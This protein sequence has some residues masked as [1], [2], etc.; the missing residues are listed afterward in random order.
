MCDGSHSFSDSTSTTR[1]AR[2]ALVRAWSRVRAWISRR[3]R[4]QTVTGL[5]DWILRDIG[6]DRERER[7]ARLEADTREAARQYW[8][9]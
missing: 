8:L 5:N 6:M 9:P 2:S 3:R 7:G 4:H 1:Q